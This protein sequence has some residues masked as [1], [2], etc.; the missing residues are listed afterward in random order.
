MVIEMVFM[1][2]IFLYGQ[3]PWIALQRLAPPCHTS[4]CGEKP[5]ATLS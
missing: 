5:N 3:L 1:D 4:P 2:F